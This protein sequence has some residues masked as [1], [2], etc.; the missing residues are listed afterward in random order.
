MERLDTLARARDAFADPAFR[1]RYAR[2][3]LDL[4]D[5]GSTFDRFAKVLRD[6]GELAPTSRS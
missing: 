5:L 2:L 4:Y 1:S 3:R 6:G